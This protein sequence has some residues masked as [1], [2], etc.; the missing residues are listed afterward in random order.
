M[1]RLSSASW[2][3]LLI[4]FACVAALLAAGLVSESSAKWPTDQNANN[5]ICTATGDLQYPTIVSDGAGER[6]NS[7]NSA[8]Q[9]IKLRERR[10]VVNSL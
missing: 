6:S 9:V 2:F 4:L 1:K 7:L 5:A 8:R 10:E 3:Q